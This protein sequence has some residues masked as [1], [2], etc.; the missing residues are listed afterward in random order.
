MASDGKSLIA[1][2]LAAVLADNGSRVVLVDGD[3]RKPTIH[4]QLICH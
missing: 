3:L 1:V 4:T 2:N